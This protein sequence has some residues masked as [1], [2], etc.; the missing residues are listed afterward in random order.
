MVIFCS[1]LVARSLAET[2]MMPLASMSKVTSIW[3]MPRGAG[4]IPT[5]VNRPRDTLSLAMGLS[6]CR[7]LISTLV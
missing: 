2:W 5:R 4:G 3:G 7:T 1:F 6:P